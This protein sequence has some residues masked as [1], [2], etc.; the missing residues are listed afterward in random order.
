MYVFFL[1]TFSSKDIVNR[2]DYLT[3]IGQTLYYTYDQVAII[4]PE[5]LM[6]YI[7]GKTLIK[8]WVGTLV[9]FPALAAIIETISAIANSDAVTA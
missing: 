5:D 7:Y 3:R 9:G 4:R 8:K 1:R 6:P 2:Y